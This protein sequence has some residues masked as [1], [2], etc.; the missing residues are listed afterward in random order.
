MTNQAETEK[1]AG[2]TVSSSSS[3]VIYSAPVTKL[4]LE[5]RCITIVSLIQFD[6]IVQLTKQELSYR[7]QIA[8]QLHKH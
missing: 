1:S 4:K 8:R 2:L 6:K 3:L 5:H 7:K